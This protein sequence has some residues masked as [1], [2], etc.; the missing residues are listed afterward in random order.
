M[1]LL[2]AFGVRHEYYRKARLALVDLRRS[3]P[4]H[5][6]VIL[7]ARPAMALAYEASPCLG[8]RTLGMNLMSKEPDPIVRA[9]CRLLPDAT[10]S[11]TRLEQQLCLVWRILMPSHIPP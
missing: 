4:M 9:R 5:Y 11:Q 7:V 3:H 1:W 8:M 2:V 6:L 10:M